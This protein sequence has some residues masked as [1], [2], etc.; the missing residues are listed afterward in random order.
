MDGCKA[1]LLVESNHSCEV[2]RNIFSP[3]SSLLLRRPVNLSSRCAHSSPLHG[4]GC[5]FA[6]VNSSCRFK[7]SSHPYLQY[8][9]KVLTCASKQ[10]RPSLRQK[11]P[12]REI[13]LKRQSGFLSLLQGLMRGALH[14]KIM[15]PSLPCYRR[16]RDQQTSASLTSRLSAST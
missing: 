11:H 2:I 16:F 10:V 4:T 5:P 3:A 15:S 7:L 8:E 6:P 14:G 12:Q 13:S 9:V 1:P